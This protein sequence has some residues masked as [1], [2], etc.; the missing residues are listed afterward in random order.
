MAFAQP[1]PYAEAPGWANFS[2]LPHPGNVSSVAVDDAA[3][4]VWIAARC[5]AN[6]CSGNTTH[7]PV[8]GLDRS[9][10]Q[11]FATMGLAQYVWPH[12]I[13]V[14]RQGNIWVTDGRAAEG[15]GAQVIKYA[16]DGRELMRLGQAGFSVPVFLRQRLDDLGLDAEAWIRQ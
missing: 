15:R 1:N 13:H 14:D 9:T 8:I 3:G 7:A 16:P 10:G 2:T 6:D 5:G 4:R 12:G 11:P